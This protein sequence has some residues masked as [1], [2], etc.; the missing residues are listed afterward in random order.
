MLPKHLDEKVARLHLDALGVKLTE[1]S[2]EQACRRPLSGSGRP[3]RAGLLQSSKPPSASGAIIPA[4]TS[5]RRPYPVTSCY[6]EPPFRCAPCYS[7]SR[8]PFRPSSTSRSQPVAVRAPTT[9]RWRRPS[10]PRCHRPGARRQLGRV[11]AVIERLAGPNLMLAIACFVDRRRHRV[12]FTDGE[13]VGLPYAALVLADRPS[14]AP[15]DDR[16]S[17]VGPEEGRRAPAPPVAASHRRRHR[18]RHRTTALRHRA[19]SATRPNASCFIRSWSTP[20]SGAP[21]VDVD[22]GRAR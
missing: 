22:A 8:A 3:S 12:V 13:Q 5:E 15:R 4:C 11:G 19:S 14:T 16:A 7:P 10:T 6:R 21:T 20:T 18:V 1:L 17:V 9:W 2:P